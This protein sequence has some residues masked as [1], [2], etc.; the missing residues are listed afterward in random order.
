M[1]SVSITGLDKLQRDLEQASR[2]FQALDGTIATPEFDSN[3]LRS[4]DAA[5][6]KMEQAIDDKTRTYRSNPLVE[7]VAKGLKQ[8]YHEAL[9]DRAVNARRVIAQR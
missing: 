1:M 2:A 8:K 3:D 6:R 4:V 7:N 5:V 9:L